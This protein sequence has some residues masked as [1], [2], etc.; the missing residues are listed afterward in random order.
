MLFEIKRLYVNVIYYRWNTPLFLTNAIIQSNTAAKTRST[1]GNGFLD[2]KTRRH[3][4]CQ[5]QMWSTRT[6]CEA[7]GR[8][9]EAIDPSKITAEVKVYQTPVTVRGS[10]VRPD[11]RRIKE[12]V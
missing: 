11:L 4:R 12:S 5:F 8:R 3:R 9:G 2:V 7:R 6:D 1:I 10:R